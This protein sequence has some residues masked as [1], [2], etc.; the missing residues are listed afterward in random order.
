VEVK[1][2]ELMSLFEVVCRLIEDRDSDQVL[3]SDV[4]S[5]HGSSWSHC[6]G[7]VGSFKLH[8]GAFSFVVIHSG[9]PFEVDDNQVVQVDL[10]IFENDGCVVDWHLDETEV[11]DFISVDY[12]LLGPTNAEY[13][14]NAINF[15]ILDEVLL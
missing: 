7:V 12:V 11:L 14:G 15:V 8:K 1:I 13:A 10:C 3:T 5:I 9:V 6:S 2:G 4:Y